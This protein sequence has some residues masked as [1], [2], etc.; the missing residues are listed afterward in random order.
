MYIFHW[1][2][3]Q[4]FATSNA[5]FPYLVYTTN[6]FGSHRSESLK[7]QSVTFPAKGA[8]TTWTL[9]TFQRFV[10]STEEPS[11]VERNPWSEAGG[12]GVGQAAESNQDYQGLQHNT[13]PQQTWRIQLSSFIL[14]YFVMNISSEPSLYFNV[15]LRRHLLVAA[16]C[17][18]C[19]LFSVGAKQIYKEITSTEEPQGGDIWVRAFY[20]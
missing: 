14:R 16:G 10:S 2:S 7:R 15:G 1:Y 13:P 11:N 20:H 5:E 18:L 6:L 19:S 9:V 17:K 12:P 8:F 3:N 4:E